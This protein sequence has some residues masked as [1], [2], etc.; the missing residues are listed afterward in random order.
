M[1]ENRQTPEE[2]LTLILESNHDDRLKLC[3]LAI[4]ASEAASA[5]FLGEHVIE[6][7]NLRRHISELSLAL[8]AAVR[9]EPVDPVLLQSV[10]HMVTEHM[11]V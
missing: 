9:G 11:P 4:D 1:E 5:C 6:I 7:D 2:L 8:L 10:R 3:R